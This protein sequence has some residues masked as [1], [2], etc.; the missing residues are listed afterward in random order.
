[1]SLDRL[2]NELTASEIVAAGLGAEEVA[3]AC[4]DRIAARDAAVRAWS[5]VDPV[6]VLREAR[7]IDKRLVRGPLHGVPVGVKDVIDTADMP[8]PAQLAAVP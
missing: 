3:R 8:T 1:M 5:F 6:A 7:E 4:L 2:L